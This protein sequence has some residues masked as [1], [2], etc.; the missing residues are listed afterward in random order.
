M[1]SLQGWRGPS[2]SAWLTS[3]L[4]AAT[5]FLAVISILN[6]RD[7]PSSILLEES[8]ETGLAGQGGS[9]AWAKLTQT[10]DNAGQCGGT[11]LK[12]VP[13]LGKKHGGYKLKHV[14]VLV[15]HGDRTRYGY[16]A[17]WDKD[18]AKFD[19]DLAFYGRTVGQ[20]VQSHTKF[21]RVYMPGRNA[22]AGSCRL[23]QL[24]PKGYHQL[25]SHGRM[26]KKAYKL[27]LPT[28]FSGH[29]KDFVLRSD[30]EPRTIMSGQALFNGMYP[31]AKEAEWN[32]MDRVR[33]NLFPN[34]HVCP[35]L[36]EA[37]KKA[38]S[39]KEYREHV[40]KVQ[41]PL[42][43]KLRSL[44]GSH[45]VSLGHSN[46][47]F[48]THM[49][50]K[51]QVPQMFSPT[52]I[53]QVQDEKIKHYDMVAKHTRKLAGGPLVKE[54][55]AVMQAA[56]KAK[57]PDSVPKFN[58]YS[59][60]DTGPILPLLHAFKVADGKWPPYAAYITLELYSSATKGHAVRM[61]YNGKALHIPGCGSVLCPWKRFSA[62][63]KSVSPTKDDCAM[64]KRQT[65]VVHWEGMLA[66][67]AGAQEALGDGGLLSSPFGA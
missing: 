29:E 39:T 25:R 33:D 57:V 49:C 51:Q 3:T 37:V 13:P 15:R 23:G 63:A 64:K 67:D 41:A 9:H 66:V 48:Q 56:V 45:F 59:G 10:E 2:R 47:C 22:L 52:L 43:A 65:K 31:T 19:C 38:K 17:C 12:S 18:K 11:S 40:K 24:T 32:V 28:K 35:K 36:N 44:K 50:H 14:S 61:V 16:S 53:K 5:A 42:K 4:L 21:K 6:S 26:L 30:D 8:E 1:L 46:D 34:F 20:G 55:H 58:L 7:L 60:H 27:L 62:I 54:L